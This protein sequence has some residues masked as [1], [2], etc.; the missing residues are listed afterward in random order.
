MEVKHGDG[1]TFCSK[2]RIGEVVTA[3][4]VYLTVRYQ[5]TWNCLLIAIRESLI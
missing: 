2:V 5:Q 4:V 1:V 3:D